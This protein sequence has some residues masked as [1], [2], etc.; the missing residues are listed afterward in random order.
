[1]IFHH[2]DRLLSRQ[3][4]RR[5]V[6][7]VLV[8]LAG[9]Q[10]DNGA[11]HADRWPRQEREILGWRVLISQRLLDEQAAATEQALALLTTQLEEIIR[12][13]PAAAVTKLRKVPLYLSPAYDGF[14]A[15]AEYHPAAGWLREH[16]RDPAM[17][18][19]IEFT[20]VLIF[21]EET[22]RMPNFTLHELAHAY[23][24]RELSQGFG[25]PDV[26]A[27]FERA[28]AAGIYDR[29]ERQDAKGQRT[30]DRAYALTNPQE[31][32]AETTEAYF[33]RN[34]FFPFCREELESHDRHACRMLQRLWGCAVGDSP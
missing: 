13:M 32:F 26:I 7:I 16:G 10:A 17:E 3:I 28:R 2:Q 20:N 5:A 30:A 4:F 27:A 19:A 12:V 24:D 25:N 31:Y 9:S 8:C 11:A 1:V 29:V 6:T 18:K 22:R 21:E 33:S 14:D 34:D 15:A 23:H